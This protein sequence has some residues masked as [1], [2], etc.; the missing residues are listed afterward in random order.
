MKKKR[1]DQKINNL[2]IMKLQI[3]KL[4]LKKRDTYC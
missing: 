4:L 2:Q 3:I 1:V